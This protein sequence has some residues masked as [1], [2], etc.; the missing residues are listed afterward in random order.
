MRKI[1]LDCGTNLGQGLCQFMAKDIIDTDFDIHCF[2]PNPCALEY[3]KK[4]F[5]DTKYKD[6]KI[7]FHEV[8]LWTEECKKNFILEAF[9]GEYVCMH[10]GEHLGYDL[11]SGGASTIMGDKWR[12]PDWISD[13]WLSYDTEVNCIDFSKF[14]QKNIN[15]GD[16]VICK[17]DIEGA[18]FEIIPKLLKE[19]TIDL[20][21]EIYIEWHDCNNLVSDEY[22]RHPLIEEL[23]KRKNLKNHCWE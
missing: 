10:T 17:M 15:V 1:F 19:N 7:T 2:E 3:S 11:K 4:R 16:Y 22:S 23:N 20:I 21:K 12:K 8:A 5:S 18:E 13:E 14:L 6:Y 9:T